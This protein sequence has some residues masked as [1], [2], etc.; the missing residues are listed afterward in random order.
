[1]IDRTEVIKTEL[2]KFIEKNYC[3]EIWCC[4]STDEYEQK[5]ILYLTGE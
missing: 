3:S 2:S 1:M 4:K 5:R